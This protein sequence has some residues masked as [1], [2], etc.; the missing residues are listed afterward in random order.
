M[1]PPPYG[2]TST[3]QPPWHMWGGTIFLEVGRVSNIGQQSDAQIA[4]ISFRRPETWTFFFGW[5]VLESPIN[6]PGNDPY[7]LYV[8]F[9]L[10]IGVGR[11]SFRTYEFLQGETN[12]NNA[13]GDDSGHFV[14]DTLIAPVGERLP[15]TS[16]WTTVA[17]TRV[18][19]ASSGPPPLLSASIDKFPAE[20][21]QCI[22]SL[23]SNSI[24]VGTSVKVE[25][26]AYFAPVNHIRPDWY[27]GMGG[28]FMGGET[29]GT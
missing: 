29:G 10:V 15:G 14:K 18:S 20:D 17:Q 2:Q 23:G 21:I 6:P 28:Q 9:D 25:L 12:L 1:S 8:K 16:F 4:R 5:R 22:G 11:S 26:S 27:A 3:P 13:D 24:P 7:E 19:G